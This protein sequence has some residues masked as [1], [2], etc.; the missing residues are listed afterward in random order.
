MQPTHSLRYH[1][2]RYMLVWCHGTT[3]AAPYSTPRPHLKP[4]QP[5]SRDRSGCLAP[6]HAKRCTWINA[7][8]SA[9]ARLGSRLIKMLVR[10]ASLSTIWPSNAQFRP[11]GTLTLVRMLYHR[12]PSPAIRRWLLSGTSTT[13]RTSNSFRSHCL[14]GT[15]SVLAKWCAVDRRSVK[16]MSSIPMKM[17]VLKY[18]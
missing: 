2:Q 18:W 10:T 9:T 6:P 16:Q 17:S 11:Y 7:T 15:W 14:K 1:T 5:T 4:P 13:R 8:S 12:S 3:M